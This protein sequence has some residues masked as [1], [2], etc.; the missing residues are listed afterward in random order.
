[1]KIKTEQLEGSKVLSTFM[2]H[3]ADLID[4]GWARP[5]TPNKDAHKIIYAV[6]EDE[7]IMGGIVYTL[8]NQVKTGWIIFAFTVEA[9]RRQGVYS[10]LHTELEKLMLEQEMK[11]VSSNVHVDNIVQIACCN[12]IGKAPEFYRMNKTLT[13]RTEET[14][15]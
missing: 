8:N 6:D 10:A 7:S 9:F 13:P 12:H 4:K 14:V 1:M 3:Y 5:Y 15:A 11:E 2:R